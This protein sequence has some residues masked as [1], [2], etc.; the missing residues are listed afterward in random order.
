MMARLLVSSCSRSSRTRSFYNVAV[1]LAA[2]GKGYARA[3]IAFAEEEA[4]RR[5]CDVLRLYTHALMVE[6]IALYQRLG[7]AEIGRIQ[8][9][10]F[11]RVY[12]AKRL[13]ET[14]S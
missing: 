14:A 2:Q 13:G 10:G 3:L 1:R 12:M 4:A 9:K 7:F 6:N 8:E 11:D 5:G